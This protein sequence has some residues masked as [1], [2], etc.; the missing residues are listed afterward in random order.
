MK[1]IILICIAFKSML[2]VAQS[3]TTNQLNE[4][5]QREG[6]WVLTNKEI[7]LP[8]YTDSQKI[9]E[10]YYK[11]GKKEG[12]WISYF[13]NGKTKQI[14]NYKNGNPDGLTFFYFKNGNIRESGTWRNNRWVG[15]YKL[16]YSNGN[17]K[18]HFNYNLQGVKDGEQ[19]YFH[20]NGMISVKGEWQ[21]GNETE[22]I[23]EYNSNGE[24]NT[25]R[26]KPGPS[27]V[28]PVVAKNQKS[29]TKTSL[30]TLDS[31]KNTAVQLPQKPV[32]PFNGNG[33]HEFLDKEGNK[34]KVGEFKNGLLTDG[35]IFK[36][37]PNGKLLETRI[38]KGGNVVKV[39]KGNKK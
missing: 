23:V 25:Q 19:I 30:T 11:N 21:N 22:N 35:K 31:T 7:P 17:L 15:D 1:Y 5:K 27:L 20:E 28:K 18:N 38:V 10:G 13:N 12:K 3:D 6:Y 2:S 29:N 8:A 14:L 39:I 26:Y 37:T 24:P 16:Y 9:E 4:N 36:Y 34:S 33:Y 32:A